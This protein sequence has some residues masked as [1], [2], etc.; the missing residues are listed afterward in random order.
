[1]TPA[2][3]Y[4]D[5]VK[6]NLG[7]FSWFDYAHHLLRDQPGAGD[8]ASVIAR[9]VWPDFVEVG[10]LLFLAD[11]YSL[12]KLRSLQSQGLDGRELEY[13][14]NLFSVDGFFDGIA[15]VTL[16]AQKRLARAMSNA[17][18][19]KAM[20]EYP[21]RAFEVEMIEDEETGDIC[22]AFTQRVS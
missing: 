17:W 1:M 22:V 13:W 5:W 7:A 6:A 2:S 4:H 19:A 10:R 8:F 14:M 16:D 12:E 20:Q 11:Q 15:S 21:D 18:K 9:L 3:K